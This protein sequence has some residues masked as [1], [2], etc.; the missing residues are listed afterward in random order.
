MQVNINRSTVLLTN[1][2][3]QVLLYTDLPSAIPKVDDSVLCLSFCAEID[4]SI[5]Y[6]KKH[7]GLNPEIIDAR[8]TNSFRK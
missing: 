7:F 5:E 1:G 6:V 8:H 4:T 3:D 2:A